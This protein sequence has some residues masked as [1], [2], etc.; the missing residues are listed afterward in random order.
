M[1]EAIDGIVSLEP[2]VVRR[3]ISFADCDPA[4][5]VFAGNFY[6]YV[7]WAYHLYLDRRLH[8]GGGSVT[9]PMKAASFV[10]HAPL[11]PGDNVD[12]HVAATR[13]GNS[14]FSLAVAAI[15]KGRAVFDA[16]LTLICKPA[17]EWRSCP[18]PADMRAELIRDGAVE[19]PI[20]SNED[21]R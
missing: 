1:I 3:R 4:G 14:T 5:V 7:L 9:V 15:C 21:A 11:W 8:A 13:V 18:I 2:F 16:E 12:L 6:D 19:Q 10:H 17:A 20:P